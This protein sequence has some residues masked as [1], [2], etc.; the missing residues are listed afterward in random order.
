MVFSF[1][2]PLWDKPLRVSPSCWVYFW[3]KK[4]KKFRNLVRF[5]C[6]PLPHKL[7]P[8]HSPMLRSLLPLE[9]T[10]SN[11]GCFKSGYMRLYG[12]A[13]CPILLPNICQNWSWYSS[14]Y[15]PNHHWGKLYLIYLQYFCVIFISLFLLTGP[16]LYDCTLPHGLTRMPANQWV[17][18]LPTKHN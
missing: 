18:V 11:L 3:C 16:L 5:Q 1:W 6:M 13:L 8:I 4:S 17:I 12:K 14:G 9:S 15:I 10:S 7:V 2:K